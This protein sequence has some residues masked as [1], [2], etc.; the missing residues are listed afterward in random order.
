[1]IIVQIVNWFRNVIENELN[2]IF[3][4]YISMH[5]FNSKIIKIKAIMRFLSSR[6]Y[7]Y[8][9]ILFTFDRFNFKQ[10]SNLIDCRRSQ[11][12]SVNKVVSA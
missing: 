9:R 10:Q 12:D 2:Y 6:M 7:E 5:V 1:M 3:E 4:T 8:N 11:S